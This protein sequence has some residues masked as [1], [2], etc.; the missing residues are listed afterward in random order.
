MLGDDLAYQGR[1][2]AAEGF[3]AVCNKDRKGAESQVVL[4]VGDD[5][6]TSLVCECVYIDF[7]VGDGAA[8]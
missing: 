6:V 8:V 7:L 5:L 4:D 1:V 3:Y 2:E